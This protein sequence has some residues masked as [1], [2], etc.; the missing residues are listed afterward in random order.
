MKRASILYAV[1]LAAIM[2]SHAAAHDEF[3]ATTR[4]L[5]TNLDETTSLIMALIQ[6]DSLTMMLENPNKETL[7]LLIKNFSP[8]EIAFQSEVLNNDL[9]TVALFITPDIGDYQ[10]IKSHLEFCAREF[11]GRCNFVEIDIGKLFK[12]A[13]LNRISEVPTLLMLHNQTEL[14]RM[15]QDFAQQEMK[16]K[17]ASFLYEAELIKHTKKDESW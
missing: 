11:S 4:P 13:H 9:P 1:I 2:N 16:E 5:I 3:C 17:I 7:E 15:T 12:I 10:E 8:A 6:G 14:G